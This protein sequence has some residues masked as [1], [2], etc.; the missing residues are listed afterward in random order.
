MVGLACSKAIVHQMTIAH[1]RTIAQNRSSWQDYS[2][3]QDLLCYLVT[4]SRVCLTAYCGK[5]LKTV[6]MT[7]F[8]L[9][10]SAQESPAES[11]RIFRGA[12][13]PGTECDRPAD[14]QQQGRFPG[15]HDWVRD[16]Q[17]DHVGRRTPPAVER[18]NVPHHGLYDKEI[19]SHLLT[20]SFSKPLVPG[21]CKCCGS[22]E[23]PRCLCCHLL[24]VQN[25]AK[26]PLPLPQHPSLP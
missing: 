15:G 14:G 26:T 24:F 25:Y 22:A 9:T 18:T 12:A 7:L 10:P 1:R 21:F 6:R 23:N 4:P 11:E 8:H 16:A 2:L 20:F 5:D 13:S 17:A 3:V 19:V